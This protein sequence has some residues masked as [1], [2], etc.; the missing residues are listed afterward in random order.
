[1]KIFA[2]LLFSLVSISSSA[3]EVNYF[4]KLKNLFE[5]GA[6]PDVKKLLVNGSATAWSGRGFDLSN[7]TMPMNVVFL[8]REKATPDAGPIKNGEATEYEVVS[9]HGREKPANF[10]DGVS[11]EIAKAQNV[12]SRFFDLK[13]SISGGLEYDNYTRTIDFISELKTSRLGEQQFLIEQIR[14]Q[15]DGR[16]MQ[17]NYYFISSN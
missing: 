9:F 6:Q 15:D 13:N 7:P 16:V 2:I 4:E 14:D 8:I 11:F 1:M 10:Y 12:F 17:M 3:I 5:A